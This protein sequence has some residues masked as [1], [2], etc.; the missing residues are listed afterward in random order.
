[1]EGG[2]RISDEMDL[3][4][5]ENRNKDQNAVVNSVHLDQE[6]LDQGDADTTNVNSTP[7]HQ[8][9]Q[10]ITPKP[11]VKNVTEV[12]N[13][14]LNSGNEVVLFSDC[15]FYITMPEPSFRVRLD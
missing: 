14:V 2:E 3:V 9:E 8:L 1:M 12:N 4:H 5:S 11:K 10:L 15:S 6:M 7:T 13:N